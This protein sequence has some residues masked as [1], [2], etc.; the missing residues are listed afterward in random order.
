MK[1]QKIKKNSRNDIIEVA[2]RLL[3]SKPMSEITL[4]E[5][6]RQL[7]VGH[8]AIYKHFENKQ[9]LWTAVGVN[10]FNRTIT[11]VLDNLDFDTPSRS[12]NLKQWL[13]AFISL[14]HQA[15][16]DF[17]NMAYVTITYIDNDPHMLNTIL[18]DS[19]RKINFIMHYTDHDFA[20]AETIMS[21]FA[22]FTIPLFRNL[23][24]DDDLEQRFLR[25][26][27]LIEQGL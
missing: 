8:T 5:I 24:L 12:E 27:A 2:E 6:G 13:W 4:S 23:W 21:A 19:Y 18:L 10:W 7:N 15:Y 20:R 26:W 11:H 14:K 3:R 1:N 22:L 25:L 16:F 17:P 9:L